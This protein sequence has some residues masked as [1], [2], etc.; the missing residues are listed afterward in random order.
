MRSTS[1]RLAGFLALMAIFGC[2]S[3]QPV[4]LGA[5]QF[6]FEVSGSGFH[7]IVAGDSARWYVSP[8]G[9]LSV[10]I[11][12]VTIQGSGPLPDTLTVSLVSADSTLHGASLPPGHY[13]IAY[14][15]TN[16][17]GSLSG[18]QF[19]F[20][21]DSGVLTVRA[22]RADSLLEGSIDVWMHEGTSYL[23]RSYRVRG[24]YVAVP[25]SAP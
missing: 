12:F 17:A 5:G 1:L 16:I 15:P 24:A 22:P 25:Y 7:G 3:T 11:G 21:S 20:Y 9:P 19:S 10:L 23:P 4:P 18:T 6:R 2:D 13:P 8:A 14:G